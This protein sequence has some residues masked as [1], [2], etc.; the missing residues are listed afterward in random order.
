MGEARARTKQFNLPTHL[1]SYIHKDY[2]L[3]SKNL[4]TMPFIHLCFT[5]RLVFPLKE[6][7][8]GR[9]AFLPACIRGRKSFA[10]IT[11]ISGKNF[12]NLVDI[13]KLFWVNL[14]ISRI[15]DFPLF[16]TSW[17]SFALLE[18]RHTSRRKF[19]VEKCK[20]HEENC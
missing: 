20:S 7:K 14:I 16:L 10:Y 6:R 3:C 17:M 9:E 2:L 18:R 8:E 11:I 13:M 5:S 15:L 19:E 1:H 4:T 12:P